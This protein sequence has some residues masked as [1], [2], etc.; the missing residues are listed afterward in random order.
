MTTATPIH[1]VDAFTS[2]PFRGNPAA[3]CVLEAARDE[4]WMQ[5]V[6]A[7]MNL[8]ETAFLWPE[9]DAWRLRWFTPTVEVPLCGHATLASA[10][11]LWDTARAKP[12]A[13]IRFATKS[14]WL[15][16]ARED[17]WIRLDFPALP[18]RADAAAPPP[19]LLE[20]LGLAGGLVADH[21]RRPG[22][23]AGSVTVHEVPRPSASDGPSWLVLLESVDALRGL[24]P[25]FRA[26][27]G[28]AGHAVIA[29]ARAHGEHDFA[30]RFF[31]PKAGVDEDPVTG[32]AH[33]SL[34]PFWCAR[35]GRTELSGLQLSQR[36]GVV[37]VR[38]LGDRVHLLGQ[39][40]TVLR[41]E[42]CA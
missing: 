27:R 42:L 28:V 19:G 24:H 22:T 32:S 26:L 41:G 14:G 40:V 4:A 29:T 16:A 36:T 17:D 20:A 18:P 33:C 15:T 34:A 31:A 39:A 9:G 5:A 10:H 7:E 3:V 23:G 11:V 38:H 35:L 25:D 1:Q 30:S 2:S 21:G 6:A 37:R 12:G 13:E 8:A